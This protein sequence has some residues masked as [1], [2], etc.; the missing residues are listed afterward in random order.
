[1]ARSHDSLCELE[2]PQRCVRCFPNWLINKNP[3]RR[4]KRASAWLFEISYQFGKTPHRVARLRQCRKPPQAGHK[5]AGMRI[6]NGAHKQS[7]ICGSGRPK[8]C[9]CTVSSDATVPKLP[10]CEKSAFCI[11]VGTT[12]YVPRRHE[13]LAEQFLFCVHQTVAQ[14]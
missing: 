13:A 6:C 3:S 9:V 4:Q 5:S 11:F 2:R 10:I 12:K 14:R 7:R 8:R 1:M